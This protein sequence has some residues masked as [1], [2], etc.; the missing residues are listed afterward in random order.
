MSGITSIKLKKIKNSKNEDTVEATVTT[1][2]NGKGTAS[3]PA[4]TSAGKR[5][6]VF[7]PAP[8]AKLIKQAEK[9]LVPKLLGV[10]IT[11]QKKIDGMITKVD[12]TKNL[13]KIG[14]AVST[15]VSIA[16]AKTAASELKK[17]LYEYLGGN[18]IPVL[19]GVCIGGGSHSGQKSTDFQEFLSI[20]VG[21][22][23]IAQAVEINKKV[24]KK[25]GAFLGAKKRDLEGAFVKK[26]S[27]ESA[28]QALES[29]VCDVSAKEG[30]EIAVG[31][32]V[33][34]SGL[35]KS[36]K[37]RYEG[38]TYTPAQHYEN[39][40]KMIRNYD[41]YYI[42]DPFHE[43]DFKSHAKLAKEFPNV[44]VCGD[45][46]FTT[47]KKRLEAGIKIK[48]CNAIIIKPNQAGLLSGVYET[49]RLA[50]NNKYACVMSHR[51]GE[52]M[53]D[54]LADLCVGL[55]LPMMKIGIEGKEREAKTKRLIEIERR[56]QCK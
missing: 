30:V 51:S 53:D 20:P 39:I 2:K 21:A 33:A 28:L 29:A 7:L 36:G 55:N 37:Y 26:M 40:S 47:N 17:S 56:K 52:T 24:L 10:E 45:D 44:L 4:G 32:D 27:N 9:K 50:K 3:S 6:A 46:L 43:D 19:L 48:A 16:C 15:A 31:V 38:K 34:A 35:W 41:I 1:E 25:T 23:S 12:G 22:A 5:E 18:R 11:D 49:V 54:A 14:G 42:E 8:A 13:G